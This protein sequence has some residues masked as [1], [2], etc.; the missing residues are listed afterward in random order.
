VS[1]AAERD[2][3]RFNVLC[4]A[5]LLPEAERLAALGEWHPDDPGLFRVGFG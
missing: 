3:A 2:A 4:L 1:G 5:A